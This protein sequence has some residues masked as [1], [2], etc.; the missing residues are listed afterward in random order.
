[1]EQGNR[2][3][4]AHWFSQTEFTIQVFLLVSI[5]S[6]PIMA[7]KGCASIMLLTETNLLQS[8]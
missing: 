5:F 6:L 7:N 4:L 2:N 1:M 8:K 3:I